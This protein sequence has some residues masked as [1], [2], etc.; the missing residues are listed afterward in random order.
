MKDGTFNIVESRLSG[1]WAYRL[2]LPSIRLWIEVDENER[3]KRVS[4]REGGTVE[5]ALEANKQR[6]VVDGKRFMELYNL[7]PE[8]REP[9]TTVLD[10]TNLTKQQ[11]LAEVV[12][13]LEEIE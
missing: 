4:Y 3:A 13:I 7:L 5:E 11:V 10:A 9:Y 12:K 8:Q 6:S 2:K 1:W